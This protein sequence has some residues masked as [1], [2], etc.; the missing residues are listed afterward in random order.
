LHQ[1]PSRDAAQLDRPTGGLRRQ[2]AQVLFLSQ[3]V[4]SLGLIAGRDHDLEER[5]DNGRGGRA[6]AGLVKCHD[7]SEG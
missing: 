7:A 2:H 4:E 1:E 5:L 3:E 6:I